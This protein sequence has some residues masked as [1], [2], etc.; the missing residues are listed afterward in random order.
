M[1]KKNTQYREKKYRPP[2][3]KNW[4]GSSKQTRRIEEKAIVLALPRESNLDGY[5]VFSL[6]FVCLILI[7][8]MPRKERSR[9]IID[10]LSSTG[11]IKVSLSLLRVQRLVSIRI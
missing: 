6:I 8:V 9:T 5:Q 7:S 11:K 1:T 4:L 10:S 2:V 3:K